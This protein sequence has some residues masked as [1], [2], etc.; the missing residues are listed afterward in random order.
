MSQ[1]KV[2]LH[3]MANDSFSSIFLILI[4][5]DKNLKA[6]VPIGVN[7]IVTTEQPP[8]TPP[9][10]LSKDPGKQQAMQLLFGMQVYFVLT[11]QNI[12]PFLFVIK[13]VKKSEYHIKD[14]IRSGSEI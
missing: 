5:F 11:I 4:P 10:Q 12:K 1:M 7:L 6:P 2:L 13:R 3:Y 14:N 9:I 8:P